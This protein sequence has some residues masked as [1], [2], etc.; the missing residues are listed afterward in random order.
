MLYWLYFNYFKNTIKTLPHPHV[1]VRYL[2]VPTHGSPPKA[3]L[4][5]TKI[6]LLLPSQFFL[7]MAGADFETQPA[8]GN[9]L[10]REGHLKISQLNNNLKFIFSIFIAS[11]TCDGCFFHRKR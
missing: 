11:L 10:F 9:L 1:T 8:A 6:Q 4:E 5:A 3:K 7:T 2:C